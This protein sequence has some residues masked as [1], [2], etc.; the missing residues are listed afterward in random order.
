MKLTRYIKELGIKTA[1]K[2][3]KMVSLSGGNQ[4][5]ALLARW[6]SIHPKVLLLDEPTRGGRH[7]R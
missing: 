7:R 5:K 3:Q 6:L 4:Q 2:E 1:S